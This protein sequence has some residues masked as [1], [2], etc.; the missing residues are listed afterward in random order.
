MVQGVL[1]KCAKQGVQQGMHEAHAKQ[2]M[3][4]SKA[5]CAQNAG[6]ERREDDADQGMHAKQDVKTMQSKA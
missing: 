4:S 3:Q 2:C 1:Q 6:K 5:E